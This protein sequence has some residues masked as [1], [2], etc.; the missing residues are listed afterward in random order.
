[1]GNL[2]LGEYKHN[3]DSRNRVSLPKRIRQK[4]KIDRVIL[5]KG[6][7]GC[8]FGFEKAVWEKEADNRLEISLTDTEA[9]RLRR[10]LFSAAIEVKLDNLG[11]VLI[12]VNLIEHAGLVK[13][14]VII[15]AGDHFEIWNPDRWGNELK[16]L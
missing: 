14:A 8:I 3:L 7:E 15:G 16:R 11:R 5:S 4:V 9:R 1:M 13:E 10:Y 6:F 2:F 12:P